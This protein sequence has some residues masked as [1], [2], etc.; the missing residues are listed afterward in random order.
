MIGALLMS[1]CLAIVFLTRPNRKRD[2]FIK[3]LLD[4]IKPFFIKKH[5]SSDYQHVAKKQ[6]EIT[7]GKPDIFI[8][9]VAQK[10]LTNTTLVDSPSNDV[11]KQPIENNQEFISQKS[12]SDKIIDNSN[13]I[14]KAHLN[15]NTVSIEIKTAINQLIIRDKQ[16]QNFKVAKLIQSLSQFKENEQ[17]LEDSLNESPVQKQ[18]IIEQPVTVNTAI[19]ERANPVE[20]LKMVTNSLYKIAFTTPAKKMDSSIIDVDTTFHP[21][22]NSKNTHSPEVPNWAHT[23]IYGYSEL[24][25]ASNE[26]KTFYD[27]FKARFLAG[28]WVDLAGNTNYAFIL[29]FDLLK[30]FDNHKNIQLLEEQ[31]NLISSFY[32]KTSSYAKRFLIQKMR[33]IGDQEGLD[34]LEW[35][36]VNNSGYDYQPWDWKNKYIKKLNLSK[37]DAKLLDDVYMNSNNFMSIEYCA[38]EVI[39]LF[40]SIRK[41]L[42]KAYSSQNL[43]QNS[44]LALVLDVVARKQYNYRFNSQN[45]QYVLAHNISLIF[46]FIL[47]YCENRIRELY[48]YNRKLSFLQNYHAEVI[49]AIETHIFSFI[50][51]DVEMLL[52]QVAEP[53]ADTEIELNSSAPTRWKAKLKL[54]QNSFEQIG[55]EA[56]LV[57]LEKLLILNTK[58]PSLENI[59]L[60]SY[61][62]LSGIDKQLAFEY[63]LLY[64]NQNMINRK[65]VLKNMSQVMTKKLFPTTEL[66]SRYFKVILSLMKKELTIEEALAEIKDFYQPV[67]KK[68]VLNTQTIKHVEEQHSGTVEV[69]NE[70]LKD[71]ESI[72]TANNHFTINLKKI[73]NPIASPIADTKSQFYNFNASQ[74][75]MALINHFKDNHF[76]VSNDQMD[77]FCKSIGVIKGALINNLNENCYDVIDDIL[78]ETDD[79]NY[80]INQSY[81]EQIINI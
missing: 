3:K 72:E 2:Q 45:Y 69:L 54:L 18:E 36:I 28:N 49:T 11:I 16:F 73:E 5:S 46:N 61:K 29:L 27:K 7:V 41:A 1:L 22:D 30:Q 39:K 71:D 79:T 77:I 44:Q 62:F 55:K 63:F 53:D 47:K 50:Q 12:L 15:L 64:T 59:Y 35:T 74:N 17:R 66:Q 51:Y 67:R 32:S 43:N 60:E 26:Q 19:Y 75:E 21:I 9:T 42:D 10:E 40:I 52:P 57:Q 14:E 4:V 25:G 34:R 48:E 81:Y 8:N 23:Y 38:Y 56:F 65:L 20:I 68:I 13:K 33:E 6:S 31:M 76:I 78:I 80:T 58:N 37:E 70:Y 24:E